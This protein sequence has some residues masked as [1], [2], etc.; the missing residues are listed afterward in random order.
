MSGIIYAI[1]S[2]STD[3]IYI[4]STFSSLEKRWKEHKASQRLW[5]K[6]LGNF[7]TAFKIMEFEDA[8]IVCVEQYDN[9]TKEELL[10]REGEVMKETINCINAKVPGKTKEQIKKD[11]NRQ[12]ILKRSRN[13]V[14]NAYQ[15]EYRKKKREKNV[16]SC[17]NAES[18]GDAKGTQG[19]T[20]GL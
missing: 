4:G 5:I 17:R 11:K 2:E 9:I 13:P 3:D 10:K 16:S 6:G 7:T 14:W 8:E 15:R 19:T 18:C 1:T 12:T 20:E